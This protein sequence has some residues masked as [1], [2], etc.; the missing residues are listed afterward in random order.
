M[1]SSGSP[2]ERESR[3]FI[4]ALRDYSNGCEAPELTPSCP[5]YEL[6]ESGSAGCAEQCMDILATRADDTE[7]A[8]TVALGS[9][10]HIVRR[11]QKRSRRNPN[12]KAPIFDAAEI[13]IRDRDRP[14]REKR[15]VSLVRDLDDALFDIFAADRDERR[16]IIEASWDE[17]ER[18]GI[19]VARMIRATAV[20]S[21]ALFTVFQTLDSV[22]DVAAE[23]SPNITRWRSLLMEAHARDTIRDGVGYDEYVM[24]YG[25]GIKPVVNWF[26]RASRSGL[27]DA[28]PPTIDDLLGQPHDSPDD[29][30][31]VGRWLHDRFAQTYTS[32]W[33]PK[34][35]ALEW[36]YMHGDRP[37]CGAPDTMRE[38]WVDPV[39]L[40]AMLAR[41][42]TSTLME[43]DGAGNS[44]SS[45]DTG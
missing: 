38:R 32:D 8:S 34:S 20:F 24:K 19:D 9:D 40:S 45:L 28:S 22:Y 29:E 4:Q 25:A 10:I 2:E 7:G 39:E 11:V 17:L 13:Q 21:V 33:A 26:A 16:Y 18:R 44:R 15:T 35:L 43:T 42:A 36:A 31:G 6:S 30:S 12:E 23:P 37:G 27:I 14:T 3:I 1:S 41:F 5:F